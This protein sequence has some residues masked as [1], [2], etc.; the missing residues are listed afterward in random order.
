MSS[1]FFNAFTS[2]SHHFWVTSAKLF[3]RKNDFLSGLFHPKFLTI[4]LPNKLDI[5]ASK[6]LIQK[7]L[8][9][10]LHF[11]LKNI[12]FCNF[13][14]SFSELI[15]SIKVPQTLYPV[16]K[17]VFISFWLYKSAVSFL[18][19]LFCLHNYWFLVK[20]TF[21]VGYPYILSYLFIKL[22]LYTI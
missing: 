6:E 19:S 4:N 9:Y 7:C 14:F 12:L 2:F 13:I 21:L 11:P 20:I 1:S 16:F 5:F 15:P 22:N 10:K 8:A 18:L 17:G 3:Q